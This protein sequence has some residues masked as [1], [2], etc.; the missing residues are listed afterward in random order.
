[1]SI[2]H[3]LHENRNFSPSV[4]QDCCSSY[5]YATLAAQRTAL[6]V[7][8]CAMINDSKFWRN[9]GI[10][11]LSAVNP[12]SLERRVKTSLWQ[13]IPW[14][15]MHTLFWPLNA[16]LLFI[17]TNEPS[18]LI[19]Q[20]RS[21]QNIAFCKLHA[22]MTFKKLHIS[23][24]LLLHQIRVVNYYIKCS[25]DNLSNENKITGVSGEMILQK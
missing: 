11:Q 17:R 3:K 15:L 8:S 19:D 7:T 21:G 1:M 18:K 23:R 9:P 4:K 12:G 13:M 6:I 14:N 2:I 5:I 10:S 20:K 24:V 16:L 22:S 25:S